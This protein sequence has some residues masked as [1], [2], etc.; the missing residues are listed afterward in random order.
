MARRRSACVPARLAI[1]GG[2]V[3]LGATG[4]VVPL[5]PPAGQAGGAGASGGAF[6]PAT[7]P[8]VGGGVIYTSLEGD[9]DGDSSLVSSGPGNVQINIPSID[10]GFGGRIAGGYRW[11]QAAVEL[12]IQSSRHDDSFGGVT[13]TAIYTSYDLNGYIYLPFPEPHV[14][15]A[16]MGGFA[17]PYLTLN[18]ASSDGT[19]TADGRL[20]GYGFNLGGAADIYVMKNLSIDV[21]AYYH[22][23]RFDTAAGVGTGYHEIKGGD[24]N[25]DGWTFG[26][27]AS[28]TF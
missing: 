6:A 11:E 9:F 21:R 13:N 28:W 8:Y 18:H 14:K 10:Y 12:A 2:L 23:T 24:L 26:L 27:G 20:Y 25:G 16:I 15:P 7:G 4:C 1:T 19:F 22:W 5:D 17:L 3:A